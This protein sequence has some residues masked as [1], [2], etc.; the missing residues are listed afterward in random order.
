MD[1]H[2]KITKRGNY[3]DLFIY[4]FIFKGRGNNILTIFF[5]FLCVKFS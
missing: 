1:Y 2:L 4:L 3:V 5:F